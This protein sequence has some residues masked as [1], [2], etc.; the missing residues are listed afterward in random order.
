VSDDIQ[1]LIFA[2]SLGLGILL[3][4]W[5]ALSASNSAK[6][7]IVE[8]LAISVLY[9]GMVGALL[10]AALAIVGHSS[11][12]VALAPIIAAFFMDGIILGAAAIS[13]E[14]FAVVF[15][16]RH[17][18]R[19]VVFSPNVVR[20]SRY[21]TA[22]YFLMVGLFKWITDA[23]YSFFQ[24]SGYNRAFYILICAFECLCAVG[25]L[26]RITVLPVVFALSV[27]M[28]GAVYTHFHNYFAKGLPDPFGNSL[29]AFRMLILLAYIAV[30]TLR[31][32]APLLSE[33]PRYT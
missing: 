22:S 29:D 24:A 5:L 8:R 10:T 23:E 28:V 3:A 33:K 20:A 13:P 15:K 19:S 31:Q 6:S 32:D 14:V 12:F 25:L 27:E 21:L 2:A 1:L 30:A 17:D 9:L 18:L 11:D 4:L 26:L 16:S 7:Q